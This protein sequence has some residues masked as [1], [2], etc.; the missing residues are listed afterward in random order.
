MYEILAGLQL[1]G[2]GLYCIDNLFP[3]IQTLPRYTH[4]N[5]E[6]LNLSHVKNNKRYYSCSSVN[7]AIFGYFFVCLNDIIPISRVTAN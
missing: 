7:N 5:V 1:R 4:I 6:S 2:V 3:F